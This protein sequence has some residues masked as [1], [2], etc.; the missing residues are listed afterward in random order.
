[1]EEHVDL[2]HIDWLAGTER[3]ERR[4]PLGDPLLVTPEGKP[5]QLAGGWATYF[6]VSEPHSSDACPSPADVGD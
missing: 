3:F 5:T 4:L 2:F 6:R 1:V